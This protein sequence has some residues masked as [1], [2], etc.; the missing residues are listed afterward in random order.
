MRINVLSYNMS[1]ATQVNKSLGT[2]ADFVEACQ[3]KYKKG[4]LNCI[5]KAIQN[6]GKLG[7]LDLIGLQEVNSAIEERIRRLRLRQRPG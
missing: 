5:D 2:E 4:G 3:Q 7:P 6:I 1:W